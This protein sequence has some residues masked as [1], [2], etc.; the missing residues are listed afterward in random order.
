M[1]QTKLSALREEMTTLF[2]GHGPVVGVAEGEGSGLTVLLSN[3]DPRAKA[4]VRRWA[5]PRH[6]DV[7]FVVS[8]RFGAATML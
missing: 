2:V 1:E 7:T 4:D 3:D 6:L 5:A 8:G